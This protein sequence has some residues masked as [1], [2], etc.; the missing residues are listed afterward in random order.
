[1]TVDSR[2]RHAPHVLWR[3]ADKGVILLNPEDGRYY[4][5][6]AS[7]A[8]IWT[9]CDGERSAADIA[10]ILEEEYEAAPETIR[11][12]VLELLGELAHEG[13]VRAA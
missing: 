2:P 9:L 3:A 7:G 4:A 8:R 10:E 5:L 1:M 6:E 12:D 13:L 11:T